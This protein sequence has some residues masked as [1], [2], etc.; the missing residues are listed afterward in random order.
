MVLPEM[1]ASRQIGVPLLS[2]LVLLPLLAAA[3]LSFV[4]DTRMAH[5]LALGT[6]VVELLLSLLLLAVFVPG[7][8]D[9]Q[10]VERMAWMPS[11]GIQYQLGVDGLS[12]LFVPLTAVVFLVLMVVARPPKT[13]PR[14]FMAML[15]LLQSATLGMYCALDLVL[16]FCFFEA[17]LLPSYWLIRLWGVGPERQ[18]AA[19]KYVV[20]MLLGSLPLLVGFVLLGMNHAGAKGAGA[21]FDWLVLMTTPVEPGLQGL[22]FLLM[23]VG[24]AIKGPALPVH[25][26]M[27]TVVMEGP[28]SMGAYLLGLKV[29]AYGLMRFAI[30][31]APEASQQ[32]AWL[33]IGL[34]LAA[35]LYGALIALVQANLRRLVAFASVSHV[36]L[37]VAA[38]FV[39]NAAAWQGAVMLMLNAGLATAGLLLVAGFLY[40][41][42]GTTEIAALGGLARKLPK[43]AFFCFVC[44]LAL[45]G[46]PGTSGFVGELLAMSGVFQRHW[47]LGAVA[48]VGV[49]L[50][51]GYF[52]WFYQRAFF[53][54]LKHPGAAQVRDLDRNEFG[55]AALL[56][57]LMLA[58][59]VAPK[60]LLDA[61]A[62]SVAAITQRQAAVAQALQ[63]PAAP[64][65]TTTLAAAPPATSSVATA[66][67]A[68][69][70]QAAP[71]GARQ[72]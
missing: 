60:A 43:L 71:E 34:G 69:A 9:V 65:A 28:V 38:L 42:F 50:S 4:R 20:Y 46:L 11:L 8:A 14:L 21:S 51:A 10:L 68:V 30:P 67:P 32:W 31:L 6:V 49:V 5:T 25:T 58:V 53:G 18:A 1:L 15:L 70:P 36:G 56:M 55:V 44:G 52:L 22:V 63:T 64:P 16:F 27:P 7:V 59:G 12:V 3:V 17:A 23:A 2:L 54:P 47:A 13:Y 37:I 29:G 26:W 45:I 57:L 62:G 33:A 24:F 39:G 72:P 40:Q 41:R 61:T 35:L 48:A 66:P 19:A